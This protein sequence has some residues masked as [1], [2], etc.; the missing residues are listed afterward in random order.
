MNRRNFIAKLGIG[1]VVATVAPK[2]IGKPYDPVAYY[3]GSLELNPP[4]LTCSKHGEKPCD[5]GCDGGWAVARG[6]PRKHY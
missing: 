4:N 2:L 3:R 5:E 6:F 1:V